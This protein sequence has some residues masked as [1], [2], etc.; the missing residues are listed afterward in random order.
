MSETPVV[1]NEFDSVEVTLNHIDTISTKVHDTTY[2]DITFEATAAAP[3]VLGVAIEI[4]N[5]SHQSMAMSAYQISIPAGTENETLAGVTMPGSSS[6]GIN[7]DIV[8]GRV[9]GNQDFV[10]ELTSNHF[11]IT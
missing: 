1:S 8:I 4:R 3:C 6:I 2:Y 11:E 10:I 5:W 9:Y 7:N